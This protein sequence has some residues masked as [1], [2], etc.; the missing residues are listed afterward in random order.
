[1]AVDKLIFSEAQNAAVLGHAIDRPEIFSILDN[2]GVTKEWFANNTLSDFWTYILDFKKTYKRIPLTFDELI[3]NIKDDGITKN[4]AKKT[5]ELCTKNAKLH[6]WDILQ[7]KLVGWA[8]A[9]VTVD[10]VKKLAQK[11]NDGKHE[12]AFK[13]F[14]DGALELQ[15]QDAFV[16]LTQDS[17]SSSADR[18]ILEKEERLTEHERILPYGITYLQDCLKGLLPSD[19]LLLGAGTGVGKTEAARIL[20]AHIVKTTG[21]P[22]HYFALEAEN[23]EI[24]RRIK[25]G[26]MGGW[27]KEEHVDIPDGMITYANWRYNRLNNEFAA[28]EQKAQDIFN[29]DYRELHTYY[30]CKGSFGLKDLEAEVYKI[31]K[32]TSCIV[33]DHLHYMDLGENENVEMTRLVKGIK[34]MSQILKIPFI[35]VCHVRKSEK[36]FSSKRLCPSIDDIHGTSNISKICTQAVMLAPAYGF[37]STSSKAYGKPTFI[38]PV[39]IRVDGSAIYHTGVGFFDTHKSEYTQYYACG[40]INS[41]EDSWKPSFDNWPYWAD[42]TRLITDCSEIS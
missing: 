10:R 38:R 13:L 40:H 29:R 9:K 11:Y 16:G 26:L 34:E 15:K 3:E 18:V 7:T 19:V 25:Y 14:E 22:V 5:A 31:K 27:Y 42:D 23:N 21:L 2:L 35:L 30:K 24:E 37:I 28:Y 36:K 41:N 33:I 6:A 4:A 17:F 1:M 39:K 32:D 12:E 8:K 20:A